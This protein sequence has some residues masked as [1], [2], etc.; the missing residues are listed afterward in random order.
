MISPEVYE[1][2]LEQMR[3]AKRKWLLYEMVI[4]AI[5]DHHEKE[6]G[7][8][9]CRQCGDEWPCEDRRLTDIVEM[10]TTQFPRLT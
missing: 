8:T 1:D 2:L 5:R 4:W 7:G 9:V 6:L 10:D 3:A